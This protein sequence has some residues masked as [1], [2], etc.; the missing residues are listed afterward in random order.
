MPGRGLDRGRGSVIKPLRG[1]ASHAPPDLAH[2]EYR[3]NGP[4]A[5]CRPA[6]HFHTAE[7]E[8]GMTSAL[9]DHGP[10]LLEVAGVGKRYGGQCALAD[11]SFEVYRR[12]VLGIIGPNGAGKTTLLEAIAG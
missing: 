9:T 10:A 7:L 1:S 6:D 12:Q 2:A 4:N 3:S 5:A 11:I 8:T